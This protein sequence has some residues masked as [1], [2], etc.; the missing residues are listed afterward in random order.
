MAK[1]Q[2]TAQSLITSMEPL[3]PAAV[4]TLAEYLESDENNRGSRDR[5]KLALQLVNTAITMQ[6]A[7]WTQER[8]MTS[9]ART[10]SDGDLDTFQKYIR[11]QQPDF[12]RIRDTN[13]LPPPKTEGEG[14]GDD[15]SATKPSPKKP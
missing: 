10:L 2:D 14:E 8:H 15:P 1:N 4:K 5:A 7:K 12:P 13:T 6:R 3:L 11:A 9:V